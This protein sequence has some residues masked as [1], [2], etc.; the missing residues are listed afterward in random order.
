MVDLAFSWIISSSGTVCQNTDTHLIYDCMCLASRWTFGAVT[1]ALRSIF[2]QPNSLAGDSCATYSLECIKRRW[3]LSASSPGCKLKHVCRLI[4]AGVADG[5]LPCPRETSVRSPLSTS[6]GHALLCSVALWSLSGLSD[7]EP[8]MCS[9]FVVLPLKFWYRSVG[10]QCFLSF[11][12]PGA[13]CASWG[14][15]CCTVILAFHST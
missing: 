10:C 13:A 6:Q 14:P 1:C 5:L 4:L 7:A 2:A 15:L 8:V 9:Q 12:W 3:Y 11:A